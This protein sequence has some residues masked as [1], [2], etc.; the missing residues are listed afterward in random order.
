MDP[1]DIC[2]RAAASHLKNDDVIEEGFLPNGNE[3]R[4]SIEGEGSYK[5][6]SYQRTNIQVRG[7]SD[8]SY[9]QLFD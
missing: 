3:G 5:R 9:S 6:Q 4:G 1:P 2:I 8:D 7:Y